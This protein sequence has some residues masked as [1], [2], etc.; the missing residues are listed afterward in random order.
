MG[1]W[2]LALL[3]GVLVDCRVV[4]VGDSNSCGRGP[5]CTGLAGVLWP[6]RMAVR[7]DWPPRWE[8]RN[9]AV[10]GMT[11]SARGDAVTDGPVRFENVLREDLAG[12]PC[13]PSPLF[14]VPVRWKLVIVLGTNDLLDPRRNSAAIGNG[15][16]TLYHRAREVAPCVDVHVATIPPRRYVDPSKIRQVNALI[17]LSVPADRIVPFGT[18]PEEHFAGDGLHASAEGQAWRAD[19]AFRALFPTLAHAGG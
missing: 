2:W 6:E 14:G 13:L 1:G 4:V 11:V 3:C 12:A 5:N 10:A 9:R 16:V 18:E 17:A 8:L 15:V 19:T 7:P